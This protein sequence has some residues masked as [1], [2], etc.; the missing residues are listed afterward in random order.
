MWLYLFGTILA[1]NF[2]ISFDGGSAKIENSSS[3]K[4]SVKVCLLFPYQSCEGWRCEPPEGGVY[5]TAK[6]LKTNNEHRILFYSFIDRKGPNIRFAGKNQCLV[7]E[8][9]DT[10]EFNLIRSGSSSY[11]LILE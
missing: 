9:D 3:Y 10:V 4:E 2:S 8:I 7:K 11:Q 5:Y 6:G 1:T